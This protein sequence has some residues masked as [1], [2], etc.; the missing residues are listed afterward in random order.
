MGGAHG[1]AGQAQGGGTAPRAF[2]AL[3]RCSTLKARIYLSV[4]AGT[5]RPGAGPPMQMRGVAGAER[6]R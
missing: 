2:P 3:Q 1:Q 4:G 5:A 6:G